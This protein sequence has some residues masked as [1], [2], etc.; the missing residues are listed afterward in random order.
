MNKWVKILALPIDHY[1]PVNCM[2]HY[3]LYG[4]RWEN[5]G[6]FIQFDFENM[7]K[8]WGNDNPFEPLIWHAF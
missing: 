8:V 5:M 3:P 4:E 1:A 6:G 7:P 2:P